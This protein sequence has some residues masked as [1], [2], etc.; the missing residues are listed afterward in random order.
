MKGLE[1]LSLLTDVEDTF[2]E[3]AAPQTRKKRWIP[4]LLC[5]AAGIALILYV[6]ILWSV[7]KFAYPDLSG[8]F[9]VKYTSPG[10]IL[11][12]SDSFSTIFYNGGQYDC[13]GNK[14]S[15]QHIAQQQNGSVYQIAGISSA[16]AVAVK[17]E[18]SQDYDVYINRDYFPKNIRQWETDL[19]LPRNG[20]FFEAVYTFPDKNGVTRTIVFPISDDT[21]VY[22]TLFGTKD[23]VL[24][25]TN[26]PSGD[27]QFSLSMDIPSL[28]CKKVITYITEDG[29]AYTQIGA[30]FGKYRIGKEAA[31]GLM[32]SFFESAA[33]Y[34]L[35][36][37][38]PENT[39]MIPDK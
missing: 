32:Q 24:E 25:L 6:G 4:R 20:I 35:V 38:V 39:A 34:E 10:Q 31:C 28:G 15:S 18:G 37:E 29:Y 1:M 36:F 22:D 26:A 19:S 17:A 7:P 21:Q 3:E 8:R 14:T 9:P 2:I 11:T 33:G 13:R 23:A 27:Y 5:A 30:V 12:T 16:Y